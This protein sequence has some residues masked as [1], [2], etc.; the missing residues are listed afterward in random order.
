MLSCGG[1]GI[2]VTAK[3]F[4][5]ATDHDWTALECVRANRQAQA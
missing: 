3:G 4:S 2:I 5:G 1:G